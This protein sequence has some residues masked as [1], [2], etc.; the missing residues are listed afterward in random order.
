MLIPS[1]P[2][3][4]GSPGRCLQ[5]TPPTPY[6]LH[7]RTVASRAH[8]GLQGQL[9]VKYRAPTSGSSPTLPLAC[10]VTLGKSPPLSEPLLSVMGTEIPALPLSAGVISPREGA[11]SRPALLRSKLPWAQ[12]KPSERAWLSHQWSPAP[13]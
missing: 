7:H 11:F 2:I 1:F 3:L 12:E 4:P 5:P 10:W 13:V 9:W 8:L 6:N